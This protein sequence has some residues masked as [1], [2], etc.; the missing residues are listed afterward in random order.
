M[1]V[2]NTGRQDRREG[3]KEPARAGQPKGRTL[4]AGLKSSQKSKKARDRTAPRA[5]G[6]VTF[7][8]QAPS[9]MLLVTGD[10]WPSP[11]SQCNPS[12]ETFCHQLLSVSG[13]QCLQCSPTDCLSH[14]GRELFA[15]QSP[16]R[17]KAFLYLLLV[18]SWALCMWQPLPHVPLTTFV[19]AYQNSLALPTKD[20]AV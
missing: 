2:R 1:L 20:K 15:R 3:K 4:K 9:Q 6:A 7:M 12:A 19:E 8:P 16:P 13:I 11:I 10:L 14:V 5:W 18:A 17:D